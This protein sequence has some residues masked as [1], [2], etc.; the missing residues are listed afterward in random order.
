M[1]RN[2]NEAKQR[3]C[4]RVRDFEFYL[5]HLLTVIWIQVGRSHSG[6]LSCTRGWTVSIPLSFLPPHLRG[7]LLCSLLSVMVDLGDVW[8]T[9]WAEWERWAD[10]LIRL[11]ACA[12]VHEWVSVDKWI[13]GGGT[14]RLL[15]LIFACGAAS[16]RP[17]SRFSSSSSPANGKKFENWLNASRYT[18]G[19]RT[20]SY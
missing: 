4:Q 14:E 11:S 20:L 1:W 9:L 2:A 16:R 10:S 6:I 3:F 17:T 5:K 19:D 7:G 13:E 15:S 12:Q 18:V 8:W